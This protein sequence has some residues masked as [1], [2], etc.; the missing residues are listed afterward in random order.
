MRKIVLGEEVLVLRY[1]FYALS[2]SLDRIHRWR[3]GVLLRDLNLRRRWSA[4]SAMNSELVGLPREV[5]T[6]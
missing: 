3:T 1:I 6:V 4:I 5:C 2:G